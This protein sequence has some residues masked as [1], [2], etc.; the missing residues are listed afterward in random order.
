MYRQNWDD[1]RFVL[2]V[3]DTGS[4]NAAASRLG[5]THATVLRRVGMFEE[6]H[7]QPVFQKLSTG[8]RVLPAAEP[9]LLAAR[10][11]EDS[12]LAVNRAF[13]EADQSMAG[14]VRITS[15]DS[16]C[17]FVL[18][19]VIRKIAGRFPQL[20]LILLGGN[21]RRDFFRLGADIAVRPAIVNEAG[22]TGREVSRFGISLYR[23]DASEDRW[24]GFEGALRNSRVGIW[25]DEH[26]RS[27]KI[28]HRADSFV[29]LQELVAAG[30]GKAILPRFI[31][32]TDPRLIRMDDEMPGFSAPLWIATVEEMSRNARFRAVQ[33]VLAA[34]IDV[35]LRPFRGVENEW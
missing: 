14:E 1:I 30:M 12:I 8:Y 29:F 32:D 26:V 21:S 19:P 23:S 6:R 7:G 20:T 24:L 16:L 4:V 18:P 2:A 11:V 15:T 33:D 10:K 27:D 28:I 13:L 5:V 25:M 35:A 22:M 9:I 34:E 3:A 31:G 17:K